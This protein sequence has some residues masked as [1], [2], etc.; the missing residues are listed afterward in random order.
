MRA[1]GPA[2]DGLEARRQAA[3]K[4]LPARLTGRERDASPDAL[5]VID[6]GLQRQLEHGA[7]MQGCELLGAAES[8]T[9]PR[10]GHYQPIA[11]RGTG[12]NQGAAAVRCG[13]AGVAAGGVCERAL[14][15]GFCGTTW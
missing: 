9:G 1:R 7:F 4:L 5:R 13:G 15:A 6:E 10:R 8:P 11:H 14:A 3:R 12:E 2:L